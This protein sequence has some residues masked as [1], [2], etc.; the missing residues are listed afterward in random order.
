MILDTRWLVQEATTGKFVSKRP[1][2]PSP[3]SRSGQQRFSLRQDRPGYFVCAIFDTGTRADGDLDRLRRSQILVRPSFQAASCDSGV[4][5]SEENSIV[6]GPLS[7]CEP[8]CGYVVT[9]ARSAPTPRLNDVVQPVAL[10]NIVPTNRIVL[11]SAVDFESI[12]TG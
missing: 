3:N 8:V 2:L 10:A 5:T 6:A 4:V 12:T 1:L 11:F 9:G 7:N